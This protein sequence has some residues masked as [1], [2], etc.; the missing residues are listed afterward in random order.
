MR[1]LDS[2]V[3][4]LSPNRQGPLVY[5]VDEAVCFEKC[6]GDRPAP[7]RLIGIIAIIVTLP[8]RHERNEGHDGFFEL[9]PRT[10]ADQVNQ[11]EERFMTIS[12]SFE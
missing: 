2:P 1:H 11:V 10:G 9:A 5:G 4:P 12:L 8:H 3:S 7:P 6:G